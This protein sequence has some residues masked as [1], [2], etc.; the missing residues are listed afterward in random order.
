MYYYLQALLDLK[1]PIPVV[2][3]QFKDLIHLIQNEAV[4]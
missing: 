4:G 1:F 2:Q 3:M